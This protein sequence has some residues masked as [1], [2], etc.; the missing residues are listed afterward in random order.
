MNTTNT[1]QYAVL[2]ANSSC[3]LAFV[4]KDNAHANRS[5]KTSN[6]P[7]AANMA[8]SIFSDCSRCM[9]MMGAASKRKMTIVIR[10]FTSF[11]TRVG[12][13]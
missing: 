11:A 7:I 12:E 9:P 13:K 1:A 10:K 8:F 4:N 3:L 6:T 5:V 2:A